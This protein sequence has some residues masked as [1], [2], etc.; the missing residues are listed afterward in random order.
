MKILYFMP[1]FTRSILPAPKF[2]LAKVEEASA[3]VPSGS[4]KMSSIFRAA[5]CAVMVVVPNE[6]TAP[7]KIT[8]PTETIAYINP[9]DIPVVARSESS[10]LS[11]VSSRRLKSSTRHFFTT[12][13]MQSATETPCEMTVA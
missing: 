4:M 8:E 3:I 7:C 11:R 5:V 10:G 1:F 12:Y 6:L 2:W 9:I 13:Q